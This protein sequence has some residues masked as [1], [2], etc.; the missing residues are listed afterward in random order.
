MIGIEGGVYPIRKEK[1]ERTYRFVDAEADMKMEYAP[2]VRNN[3]DGAV[4]Q[5]M[6]RMRTCVAAGETKI[7]AKELDRNVKIFTAWDENK[8]YR[9]VVGD[10]IAMREDDVHDIYVVRRDI[11]LKT[12]EEID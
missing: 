1:F 4:Y 9:G 6:E 11:F 5:L 2:T 12:Y 10:F 8:Y 7:Y 3:I